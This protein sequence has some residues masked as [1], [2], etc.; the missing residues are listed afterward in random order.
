MTIRALLRPIFR[1]TLGI[2]LMPLLW[3]FLVVVAII[4]RFIRKSSKI[5]LGPEPMINNVYHKRALKKYG[6]DVETFVISTYRITS[7]FDVLADKKYN[8]LI[9]RTL[10]LLFHVFFSYKCIYIYFNGGPLQ[11][12]DSYIPFLWRTEPHLYRLAG[13]KTV[14]MPYGA[15]IQD[16]TRCPNLLFRH[17]NALNYPTS[18]FRKK[19]I[20]SQIDLWTRYADHVISGCDWV[21]FM[22]HWDTLMIA[23][24]SID[25]Q[26]ATEVQ[27]PIKQASDPLKIVHA[28]NHRHIKG[29]Q[30]FIKAV[31]ELCEEGFNIELIILEGLSNNEVKEAIYNADI[32]ADQLIIGWYAM[33]ALEGMMMRKPVLCYLRQ[34]LIDLYR[35]T[36]L[37][38]KDEIPLVNCNPMNVKETI[39]NLAKNPHLLQTIGEQSRE[40]ALKHHSL[41]SVGAVFDQINRSLG[42]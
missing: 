24:F 18:R 12:I 38:Q 2:F 15:D 7:E 27:M 20:D 37:L 1:W 26:I 3:F 22:Y 25:P 30:F 42:L 40:Y 14:V 31:K 33:F 6:Y 5:G 29:T 4:A 16:F 17:C 32:V 9:I 39:R 21:D 36:G 41:D 19:R 11:F 35:N 8:N 10:Y 13:I 28:P 34:D 23:H